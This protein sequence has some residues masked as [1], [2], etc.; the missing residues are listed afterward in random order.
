MGDLGLILGLEGSSAEGNRYLFKY[1]GLEN[2]MDRGAWLA[3]VHGVT[4]SW[5]QLSNFHF[6]KEQISVFISREAHIR[7]R[8]TG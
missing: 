7:R 3:T 8:A 4:K 5:I 1:S 6:Q 2:P